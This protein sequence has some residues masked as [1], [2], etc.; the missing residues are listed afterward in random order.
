MNKRVDGLNSN[1]IFLFFC[2]PFEQDFFFQVLGMRRRQVLKSMQLS[3]QVM[4]AHELEACK[5]C[6]L[7]SPSE[8]C[9]GTFYNLVQDI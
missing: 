6:L 1:P 8:Q 7:S 5:Q 9:S 3:Q 2:R 4:Y